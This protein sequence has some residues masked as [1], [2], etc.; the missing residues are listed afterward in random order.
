LVAQSRWSTCSGV[1]LVVSVLGSV[2]VIG[3]PPLVVLATT[4]VF[5]C[6]P[7]GHLV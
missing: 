5:V 1:R 2:V 4:L 6:G 3:T 7:V